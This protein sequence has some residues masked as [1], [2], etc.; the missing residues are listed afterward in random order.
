LLLQILLTAPF[1]GRRPLWLDEAY[2]A[3]MARESIARIHERMVYDA[4]PPLYYD[5]LHLWRSVFGE[6]EIALRSLSLLFALITT[7][8]V[9]QIALQ[10]FAKPVALTACA[11]WVLSPLGI[12]YASEARNYT[13]L[14]ALMAMYTLF[15]LRFI[16]S[17]RRFELDMAGIFLILLIY[18]HNLAWFVALA[19]LLLAL[20]CTNSFKMRSKMAL[21]IGVAVLAYIPWMPELFLQMQ[22]T[23]RTIGWVEPPWPPWALLMS[24][25]GVLPGGPMPVYMPLPELP[26][27]VRWLSELFWLIPVFLLII[28]LFRWKQKWAHYILLLAALAL[29][30]PYIYSFMGSPVY[31]V[32]RTDFIALPLFCAALAVAVYYLPGRLTPLLFTGVYAL[33]S[34]TV[35]ALM[36]AQDINH[37]EREIARYLKRHAQ[38]GDIVLCT[39]LSRPVLQYYLDKEPLGLRSFPAE[40][41]YHLAHFNEQYYINQGK[42]PLLSEMMDILVEIHDSPQNSTLW[43]VNSRR[44]I[45]Q[46]IEAAIERFRQTREAELI[47]PPN[48]QTPRMGI[49]RLGEPLFL[50]RIEIQPAP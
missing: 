35:I 31:L 49:Q 16:R 36:F 4:G 20:L 25:L 5:L 8:L 43:V 37:T 23:A 50:Q 7:V 29:L 48:I 32:G 15:L 12:F 21:L 1:L 18:T 24:L 13:L 42:I 38:P 3:I 6:S 27:R 30:G 19:T 40:M 11:F 28:N 33:Q 46:T 2:S 47:I 17:E 41:R 14:T 44:A 39:G 9:Y 22:N 45:N 26:A 34:L 10:F